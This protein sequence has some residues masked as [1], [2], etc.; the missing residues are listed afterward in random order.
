MKFPKHISILYIYDLLSDY[1]VIS[2]NDIARKLDISTRSVNR[3]VNAINDY[4][5]ELSINKRVVH[6]P[7]DG[8]YQILSHPINVT[9]DR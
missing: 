1:R 2:R 9:N 6:I 8:G 7:K 3:Y 4:F 5:D